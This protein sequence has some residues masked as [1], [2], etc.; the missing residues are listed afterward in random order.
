VTN[1][2][3][4]DLLSIQRQAVES[5]VE[6]AD[7]DALSN[8]LFGEAHVEPTPPKK[9]NDQKM[10]EDIENKTKR[11]LE[12]T[13]NLAVHLQTQV[14]ELEEYKTKTRLR[15]R[16]TW[17]R[18]NNIDAEQSHVVKLKSEIDEEDGHQCWTTFICVERRS[19]LINLAKEIFR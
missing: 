18:K 4:A 14:K 11:E 3:A 9:N 7:I 5:S 10:G 12:A 16:A 8:E 17:I 15:R 1:V 6:M 2:V 19:Y 13:Q